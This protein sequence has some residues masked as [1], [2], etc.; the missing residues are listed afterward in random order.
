MTRVL[1][2]RQ[3]RLITQIRETIQQSSVAESVKS[4]ATWV[5]DSDE[6]IYQK[7]GKEWVAAL[8]SG[9]YP[10]TTGCLRGKNGYCCWGV[11]AELQYPDQLYRQPGYEFTGE[12]AVVSMGSTSGSQS[13]QGRGLPG[14]EYI[15]DGSINFLEAANDAGVSFTVIADFVEAFFLHNTRIG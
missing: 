14:L 13:I 11:Y 1:T 4:H 7:D 5:P 10:Q 3:E 9:S 6:R 15:S 2:E 12:S 8:L